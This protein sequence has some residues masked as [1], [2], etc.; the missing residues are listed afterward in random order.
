MEILS[1]IIG[2]IW[3]WDNEIIPRLICVVCGFPPKRVKDS[4]RQSVS[5]P[6]GMFT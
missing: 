1:G 2:P 5:Q 4:A 3:S 6:N